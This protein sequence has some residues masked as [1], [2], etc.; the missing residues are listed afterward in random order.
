VRL[1]DAMKAK[2]MKEAL[3]PDGRRGRRAALLSRKT[4]RRA[5]V[6]VVGALQLDVLKAR[7]EAEYGLPVSF[8]MARFN[9]LP[10][11]LGRRQMPSNSTSFVSARRGDIARDLDGDPVFPGL[12]MRF[13][14]RLRGGALDPAI[15]LAAVKEYQIGIAA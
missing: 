2:K 4:A 8:E 12:R 9:R 10:L 7:L 5:I 1:E 13:S 14:L 6:G 11:D 15:K 3:A